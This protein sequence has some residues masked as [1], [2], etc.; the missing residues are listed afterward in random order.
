MAA[1]FLVH[2]DRIEYICILESNWV[3]YISVIYYTVAKKMVT[4]ISLLG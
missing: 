4:A 1:L 2:E 3:L